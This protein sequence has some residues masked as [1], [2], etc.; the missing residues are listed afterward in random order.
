[1]DPVAVTRH[2]VAVR[3][4]FEHRPFHGARPG[5]R[6][7]YELLRRR[8]VE[9]RGQVEVAEQSDL[10]MA[11]RGEEERA[12]SPCLDE[13]DATDDLPVSPGPACTFITIW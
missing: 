4:P 3:R 6:R 5:R 8:D 10:R 9:P 13:E 1:M 12:E 2:G 7:D 11:V